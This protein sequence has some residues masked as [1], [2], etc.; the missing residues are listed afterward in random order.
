MKRVV[1]HH[2]GPIKHVELNLKRVNVVI[3]PQS[4][5]KSCILKITCFCAWLEKQIELLQGP[6][7]TEEK[8]FWEDNL[9]GFHKLEGFM[10]SGEGAYFTYTTSTMSFTYHYDDNRFDFEWK[11]AGRWKYR[12]S[13][14]SYI[15]AERNIVSVVP[16]WM[17]VN[18]NSDNIR[19]FISDWYVARQL[20]ENKNGLDVLDLGVK[21]YYDAGKHSDRIMTDDGHPLGFS[22][23]SSGLHSLI[24]MLVYLDFLFVGQYTK[25]NPSK[26]NDDNEN[27]FVLQNIYSTKFRRG[28]GE[29]I[30]TGEAIYFKIGASNLPFVSEEKAKEC[31][32]LYEAYTQ[33]ALSDIYVEEPEQNLFPQTQ[34]ELLYDMV[35]RSSKHGDS[36]FI[37]THSPYIL[38]ALNNCMQ[39]YLV[40]DRL[41][42]N[43]KKRSASWLNP[44]EVAVWELRNGE[45]SSE[46]DMKHKTLQDEDGLIRGNYFDRIM[47]NI[48]ADFTN[49]SSYYE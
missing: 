18:L 3:G 12:R 15:P 45:L 40:R 2:I 25:K 26:M 38:Y 29:K 46:T 24:P 10:K 13:R 4:A 39:G 7:I 17:D 11:N 21:Y 42:E 44:D 5:G 8:R 28:L 20:H 32:A 36:L 14:V 16:N 33:T 47:H 41:P 6:E 30:K 19:N 9:I 48:M 22:E 49:Y 37:A 23:A 35:K 43:L 1:I 34:V 27:G 31:K